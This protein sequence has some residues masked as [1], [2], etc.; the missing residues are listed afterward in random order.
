MAEAAYAFLGVKRGVVLLDLDC[1][2][3]AH[4]VAQFCVG[5]LFADAVIAVEFPTVPTDGWVVAHVDVELAP[6]ATTTDGDV[7]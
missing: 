6:L 7:L 2:S 1:V 5:A 3:R 4:I